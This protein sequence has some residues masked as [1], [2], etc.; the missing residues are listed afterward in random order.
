MSLTVLTS[1]IQ[2]IFKNKKIVLG[3]AIALLVASIL[4]YIFYLRSTISDLTNQI[5][6]L[7][8]TIQANNVTITTLTKTNTDKDI[9][10]S[11]IS[12]LLESCNNSK[13]SIATD[14]AKID[15]IINKETTT[16][17]KPVVSKE[18]TYEVLNKT[19]SVEAVDFINSQFSTIE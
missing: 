4:A 11:S 2:Y 15:T 8:T 9:N 16:N 19:Q 1:A 14:V 10:I 3:L 17:T 6:E 12:K 13:V 5:S 7:N 18:T